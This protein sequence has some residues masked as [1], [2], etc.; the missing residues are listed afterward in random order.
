MWKNINGKLIHTTDSFRINFRTNIS[1]KIL[2]RLEQL[3]AENDT[4][5]NYLLEQGLQTVINNDFIDYNKIFRPKDRVQFQSTFDKEV[6]KQ[7]R[8][9]A[10]KKNCAYR[11]NAAKYKILCR[12][13]QYWTAD[14]LQ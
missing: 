2:D 7:L 12:S 14:M 3:A 13:P 4:Y 6:L 10:E 1:M 11:L 8:L 5:V 9:F